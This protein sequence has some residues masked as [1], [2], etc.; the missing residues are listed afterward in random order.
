VFS[1][2]SIFAGFFINKQGFVRVFSKFVPW[3]KE[4]PDVLD[5]AW[6][7]LCEENKGAVVV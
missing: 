6:S 1:Y 3:W 7:Y 5:T 4:L 2:I